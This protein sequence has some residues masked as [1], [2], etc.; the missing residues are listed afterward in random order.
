VK[1]VAAFLSRFVAA[2]WLWLLLAGE[3]NRYEWIA[4]TGAAA[5][6]ASVLELMRR[7]AHVG[8]RIPLKWIGTAASVPKQIFVDFALVTWALVRRERGTFRR[9]EPPRTNAA[10]RA[11]LLWAANFSPNAIAVELDL[12]HDLIPNRDSERPA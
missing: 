8:G 5:V 6:T 4:A 1:R 7:S 11:Y 9:R 12:L 2:W 3:W 10:T